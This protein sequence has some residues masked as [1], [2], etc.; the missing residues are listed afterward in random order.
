M[1]CVQQLYQEVKRPLR[2]SVMLDVSESMRT[3]LG[4]DTR[5]IFVKEA[6]KQFPEYMEDS[7][8]ITLTCFADEV[9][10]RGGAGVNCASE[11]S[12]PSGLMGE[13]REDIMAYWEYSMLKSYNAF[14]FEALNQT[15][16]M[17]YNEM[18]NDVD[19]LYKHVLLVIT[20][21]DVREGAKGEE[22]D[23]LY[24]L[25]DSL[26][27]LVGMALDPD[28]TVPIYALH[29]HGHPDYVTADTL[30]LLADRTNGEYILSKSETIMEDLKEMMYFF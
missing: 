7:A 26:L 11:G 4:D 1:K 23:E 14:V 24:D 27:D 17:A 8:N 20:H 5:W 22:L 30:S 29:F 18:V 9:Y 16:Q 21:P 28:D 12:W 25:E 10:E 3:S 13:A 2:L 19:G 6:M 15:Y